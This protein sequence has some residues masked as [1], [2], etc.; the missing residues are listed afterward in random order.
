M[1]NIENDQPDPETGTEKSVILDTAAFTPFDGPV[2]ADT[3]GGCSSWQANED[4]LAFAALQGQKVKLGQR[5]CLAQL[6]A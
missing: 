2:L 4:P 1:N 5:A 6:A 3:A